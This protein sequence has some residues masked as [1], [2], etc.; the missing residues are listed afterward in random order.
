MHIYESK[1]K[2][3]RTFA[4]GYLV[5]ILSANSGFKVV[6]WC[7][8]DWSLS[9]IV[10]VFY[11]LLQ[12]K[13]AC[14]PAVYIKVVQ[15]AVIRYLP[16]KDVS[17]AEI[18]LR[19]LSQ[20]GDNALMRRNVYVWIEKFN[21]ERTSVTDEEGNESPATSTTDAKIERARAYYHWRESI[22]YAKFGPLLFVPPLNHTVCEAAMFAL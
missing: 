19:L 20:Y 17:G 8:R 3:I 16:S 4:I 13:D 11:L 9:L 10:P 14:S 2:F 15:H 22:F 1:L 21:S 12:C 18:H 6:L 5:T 7:S